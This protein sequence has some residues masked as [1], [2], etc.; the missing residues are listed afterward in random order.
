MASASDAMA[1]ELARLQRR[2]DR[3]RRARAESEAIVEQAIWALYRKQ[4]VSQPLEH[5]L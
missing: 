1:V 5:G 4:R 3:D 2:L